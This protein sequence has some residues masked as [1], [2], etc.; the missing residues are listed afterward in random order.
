ME[1]MDGQHFSQ[2]FREGYPRF[3][4]LIWAYHWLQVAVYEPLLAYDDVEARQ[5]AMQ[6]ALARFWQMVE[7]AP[8]SL[9]SEMPMTPAVAPAFTERY[10]DFA[11][12]FDNLHMM[13]DVISD[14][15]VS[16]AV[17]HG[18]KRDEIY[19]QADLFRDEAAMA[20]GREAWIT[21][22]LAHGLDAQGGP[23]IGWLPAAPTLAA[24]GGH[25][26]HA[27]APAH[28]DHEAPDMAEMMS[29]GQEAPVPDEIVAVVRGFHEALAQGD[30]AAALARLHPDVR[31]HEG[32]AVEDLAEYRAHHLAA[33]MRFAS[34]I[35]R[36]VVEE[37][38]VPLG[39][40][41]ALY[42]ATTRSSGRVGE[43]DVDARG[44]E[45]MVLVRADGGW[46]IRHVHWSSR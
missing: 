27:A 41:V 6:A 12:I 28:E 39:A 34:A 46:L 35:T 1:I 17:E 36:E 3:N 25:D 16:D 21:M 9:P 14:V 19:R 42:R 22:A 44:L 33:D 37:E 20:V 23:A 32:A 18:G 5:A 43:R 45:T 24:E 40:G 11:A 4:G 38:I 15:L 30:S 10:P 29:G 26:G 7:G 8:G 2:A 13:H 31:I